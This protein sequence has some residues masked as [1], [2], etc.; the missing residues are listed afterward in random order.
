MNQV[1]ESAVIRHAGASIARRRSAA[2]VKR[3][4]CW[5]LV[6]ILACGVVGC[7]DKGAQPKREHPKARS[8]C[9]NVILIVVDTLRADK[10]GCYLNPLGLTPH[11]DKLAAEGFRFSWAFS[12][13]PWTLPATASLLT[14][15]YPQQHGAGGSNGDIRN[16]KGI[17]DD[18]RTLA[19]CFWD[20]GYDTAAIVNVLFLAEKFGLTRGFDVYDYKAQDADQKDERKATEVTDWS[21]AWI[22]SHQKKS[23]RPFFLFVHYFDPH[24]RYDPPPA[25]RRKFARPEDRETTDTLFGSEAEMLRFRRGEIPV[26]DI[27]VKRLEALYNGEVAYTDD[28]IGRLLDAIAEM[29]LADTTV[30]ALTAD[31]GEEFL[32]HNGFEHGHTLYDEMIRVPLIIRAKGGKP[33]FSVKNVGHIDVAPTLCELAGVQP[34]PVFQGRSLVSLME[35][36]HFDEEPIMSQG[37]MWEG[38]LKALR[39]DRYKFIKGPVVRELYNIAGDPR[40]QK[41]LCANT[42][43]AE[44]CNEFEASLDDFLSKI[45]TKPG[46]NVNFLSTE[47][48]GLKGIGYVMDK[49]SSKG[50]KGATS[51]STTEPTT[52]PAA[53]PSS[54]ESTDGGAP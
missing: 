36:E 1:F 7:N 6:C 43:F 49:D 31:H 40:E 42:T 24:L 41:N 25:F 13:A 47:E 20:Q 18:V 27:P 17:N 21:I 23:D 37:N 4:G 10:L 45:G 16:F 51:Q 53:A 11:I 5:T 50:A 54:P 34:D 14:S 35:Q 8:G 12:H 52:Q 9:S 22:K 19:E 33:G 3:I 29:K 39:K 28:E 48:K 26:D 38:M 15:S 44:R 30:V 46:L 2:A 32:D